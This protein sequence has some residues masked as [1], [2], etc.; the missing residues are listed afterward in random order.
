MHMGT[1][2]QL[3]T[4]F[5]DPGIW[6]L[7]A[8]LTGIAQLIGY[9]FIDGDLVRHDYSEGAV[10]AELSAIFERLGAPLPPPDPGRL[11]QKHNY[12]G[13]IIATIFTCGLYAYRWLYDLMTDGNR[14]FQHNWR[15]EDDLARG[16]QS[17]IG[18]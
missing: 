3:S 6:V 14:H 15:W 7:L 17:L 18:S 5:R 1:L 12:V 13:R 10:E 4:E 11:K 16:V 2:R 9:I 8:V